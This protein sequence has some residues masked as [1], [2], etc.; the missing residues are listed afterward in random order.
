MAPEGVVDTRVCGVEAD[1]H[2]PDASIPYP[3]RDGV[4]DEDAAC[5]HGDPQTAPGG[6]A[7]KVEDIRAEERFATAEDQ[8]RPTDG[9]NLIAQGHS[10]SGVEVSRSRKVY[11][12]P[13]A[14]VAGFMLWIAFA[15]RTIRHEYL[16]V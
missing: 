3:A 7:G 6:V 15:G 14:Y 8:D 13:V 11:R 1:R 2:L 9:G 16:C 12:M 4:G 10:F 5:A